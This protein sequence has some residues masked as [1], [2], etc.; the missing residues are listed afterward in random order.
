MWYI[1]RICCEEDLFY[2]FTIKAGIFLAQVE[3]Q[4]FLLKKINRYLAAL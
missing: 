3:Q 2:A 4:T 1:V